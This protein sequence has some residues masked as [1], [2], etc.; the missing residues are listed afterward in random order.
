MGFCFDTQANRLPRSSPVPLRL[1][2]RPD[3]GAQVEV[4]ILKRRGGQ[5]PARLHLALPRGNPVL[6][7]P[8]PPARGRVGRIPTWHP[9]LERAQPL[10]GMRSVAKPLPVRAEATPDLLRSAAQG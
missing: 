8:L 9:A 5:V 1:A 7:T 10:A 2:L 6:S 4:E 3:R